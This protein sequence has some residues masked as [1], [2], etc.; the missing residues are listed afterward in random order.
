[1]DELKALRTFVRVADL[2]GF[3]A[4]GR[5][6]DLAASVVTRLVADLE[7]RLGVRLLTR[8]T[9][10]V[11]LTPI[12]QRYLERVRPLVQEIDAAAADA[13]DAHREVRGQVRLAAPPVFAAR[14]LVQRLPGLQAKHPALAVQ[15]CISAPAAAPA[16]DADISIVARVGRLDG[17]FVACPLARSQ[18]VLCASDAYL[19]RHGTPRTPEDLAAHP[20]L[21]ASPGRAPRLLRFQH[22]RGTEAEVV[23]GPVL[24]HSPHAE[25]G[26]SGAIA[27]MGI[28]ALPSFA[29][30]GDLADGRLQRVL[31]DW[32]LAEVSL[33][34]CLPTRK[35]VPAAVRAVLEFL[36]A[37]FPVR[38]DD[39]WLPAEAPLR[40]AA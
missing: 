30:H 35:Q 37:E 15:L 33:F 29:V 24:L 9:R 20:L 34:A 7:E 38:D 22:R 39:P 1:M 12:G 27:G 16:E 21:L 2:G 18:V 4:A 25:L 26:R 10:K 17:D 28:A 11:A 13:R 8:T 19:R 14:Q 36:R 40:L 6:M 31:P 5:S 32:R 23:P 3:A